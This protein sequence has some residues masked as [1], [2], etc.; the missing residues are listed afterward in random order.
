M[1][2]LRLDRA[3]AA[4]AEI[5]GL[6]GELDAEL[7]ANYAPEQRHG[8]SLDALFEPHIRFYVAWTQ[9]GAAGCGGVALFSCFAELK[10]M[11]VRTGSRG[12]GLADAILERLTADAVGAGLKLLRLETGT[13]QAR[14]IRFYQRN[15]FAL[16]E[17]YEP[18][19]SMPPSAIETSVFMEKRI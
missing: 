11:Y 4:T 15:G 14:A 10:R 1:A 7:G 9:D 8:L 2:G 12:R 6:I 19:T 3:S 5:R 17:P 13:L 18:Y 16:C